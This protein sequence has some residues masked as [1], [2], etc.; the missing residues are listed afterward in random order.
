MNLRVQ[1]GLAHSFQTLD[2]FFIYPVLPPPLPAVDGRVQLNLHRP[3]WGGTAFPN[4]L[5]R[6]QLAGE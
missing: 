2:A 1:S 3:A 5:Q 6:H 4:S